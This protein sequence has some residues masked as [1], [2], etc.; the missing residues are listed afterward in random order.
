MKVEPFVPHPPCM[1]ASGDCLV[2]GRCLADC[3]RRDY[4]Q[5]RQDIRALQERVAQLEVR[6][7]KL[8]RR[9]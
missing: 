6:I 7:L 9:G 8:E 3:T 1:V 4:W 2:K 5:H